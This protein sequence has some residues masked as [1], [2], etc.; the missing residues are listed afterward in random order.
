MAETGK[1]MKW[2][3]LYENFDE[4]VNRFDNTFSTYLNKRGQEGWELVEHHF[5]HGEGPN[6]ARNF[7]STVFKRQ[8]WQ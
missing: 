3:Y 8:V 7:C 6:K 1:S 5:C 2:E 4:D